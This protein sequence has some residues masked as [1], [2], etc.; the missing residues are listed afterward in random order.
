MIRTLLLLLL[1]IS[2]AW[3]EIV[4][5]LSS[6]AMKDDVITIEKWRQYLSEKTGQKVRL[7][8]TKNYDEMRALIESGSIDVAYLCGA[9]YVETRKSTDLEIIAIP[10]AKQNSNYFSYVIA[11][12]ECK[13]NNFL[14]FKQ[15]IYAFSDPKSNSGS[16]VPKYEL[17]KRGINPRQFF[18]KT[19]TT[20]DHS[21]SIHAV[22]V[23]FVDGASVD[24]IV[25]DAF[26]RS[27]PEM[28]EKIKIVQKM[29]PYPSTPIIVRSN[30][31][32]KLKNRL[33]NAI[34]LMDR[35][36]FGSEILFRLGIDRFIMKEK[37]DYSS[38]EMMMNT[39]MRGD[40]ASE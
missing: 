39:V 35:E 38:I 27:Y 10:V 20:Y 9:T 8:F 30:L 31:A 12:K 25:Y 24:S 11:R 14:D 34:L 18:K 36:P 6:V 3:G 2:A 1:T 17:L 23:G 21:E 5:G 22:A 28:S 29:G 15:K 13:C 7:V 4:F 33:R 16:I 26:I 37:Y 32:T 19:I 40:R